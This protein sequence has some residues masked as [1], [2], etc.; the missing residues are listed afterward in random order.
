LRTC[1]EELYLIFTIFPYFIIDTFYQII[2]S[3]SLAAEMTL[4]KYANAVSLAVPAIIDYGAF[5]RELVEGK[6]RGEGFA[7]TH[8]T[9]KS[10]WRK[11]FQI[12]IHLNP[13]P[14]PTSVFTARTIQVALHSDR[15]CKI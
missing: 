14:F 5:N 12:D 4:V 6:G 2:Y 11:E 1:L 3:G 7:S 8:F 10:E 15:S 9:T 13:P